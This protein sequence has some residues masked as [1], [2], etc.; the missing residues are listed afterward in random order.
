[1][2]IGNIAGGKLI[3]IILLHS[4]QANNGIFS[5][6]LDILEMYQPD[7]ARLQQFWRSLQDVWIKLYGSRPVTIAAINV[8]QRIL[9]YNVLIEHVTITGT[10]I[11]IIQVT[12]THFKIGH[13]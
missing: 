8:S 12:A 3:W 10:I 1:M 2:A 13:P 11:P 5:A 7:K 4:L 6:G 9:I